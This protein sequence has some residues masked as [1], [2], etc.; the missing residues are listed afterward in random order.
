MDT[1][2][3]VAPGPFSLQESAEFGFGQRPA[4]AFDGVLRMAFCQDDL[5]YQT[6]EPID[7]DGLALP[8]RFSDW[9]RI[10]CAGTCAAAGTTAG[11]QKHR[12]SPLD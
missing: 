2:T 9:P 3:I 5:R 7:A 6:G 12:V 11:S 1:F 10:R 8:A 4:Q